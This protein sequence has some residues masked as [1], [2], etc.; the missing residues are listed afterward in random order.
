[1]NE[2]LKKQFTKEEIQQA[3]KQMTLLKSTGSDGLM[4][5]SVRLIGESLEMR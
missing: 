4:H 1:M 3:I 2:E 5:A